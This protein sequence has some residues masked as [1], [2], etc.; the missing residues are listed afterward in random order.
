MGKAI[1]KNRAISFKKNAQLYDKVR[2]SYPKYWI[3]DMQKST[4]LNNKSKI[5]EV[6]S[7]TGIATSDLLKISKHI[8]CLD[9]AKEMLEIAKGKFPNLTF[10]KSTFEDFDSGELY[11]LIIS[12]MAWHWIDP[13]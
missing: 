13:V 4:K 11:D 2:P 9:P 6:G 12:A 5:L 3:S 1:D 7:G 8:T 10:V